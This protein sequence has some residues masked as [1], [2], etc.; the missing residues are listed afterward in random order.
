MVLL[1]FFL[2]S[3]TAQGYVGVGHRCVSVAPVA[4]AFRLPGHDLDGCGRPY[5]FHQMGLLPCRRYESFFPS[6]A[7]R[8]MEGQGQGEHQDQR[9]DHHTGKQRRMGIMYLTNTTAYDST[10]SSS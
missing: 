7:G 3:K 9:G 10:E 8:R 6:G 4:I 5:R 1:Q 2:T